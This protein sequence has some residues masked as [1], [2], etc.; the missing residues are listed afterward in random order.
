MA[1]IQSYNWLVWEFGVC[2]KLLAGRKILRNKILD[3]L[4]IS[5]V[6]RACVHLSRYETCIHVFDLSCF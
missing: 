2:I 1:C 3:T 5:N 6:S 4:S